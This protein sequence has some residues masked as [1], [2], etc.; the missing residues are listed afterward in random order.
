M[1]HFKNALKIH[2]KLEIRKMQNKNY[3]GN[4]FLSEFYTYQIY[5]LYI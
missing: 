5:C 4:F 1:I 3:I 2:E